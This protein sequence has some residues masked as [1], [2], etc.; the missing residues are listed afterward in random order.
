M[1]DEALLSTVIDERDSAQ[2]AA[3]LAATRWNNVRGYVAELLGAATENRD[4]SYGSDSTSWAMH[5][6]EV[7]MLEAVAS[8]MDGQLDGS[9]T[10][11]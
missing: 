7:A 10:R 11:G 3:D 8:F 6:A 4:S 9:V 2:D 1:C 5:T